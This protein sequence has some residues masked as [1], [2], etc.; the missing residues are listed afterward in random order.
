MSQTIIAGP[1]ISQMSDA[2]DRMARA[3]NEI[4]VIRLRERGFKGSF[5]HFRRPGEGKIDLLTFHFDKRGGG[6]VIEISQ[7]PVDGITTHWGTRI[8]A[9]KVRAWD[10]HPNQRFRLQ[11]G[12]GNSTS[13]W[14]RYDGDRPSE[15]VFERTAQEVLPFLERAEAWWKEEEA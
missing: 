13:G 12:P 2:H 11:P 8:P 6:F 14:F 7:C 4:V 15:E 1:R 3:L 9:N 10:V 5:P